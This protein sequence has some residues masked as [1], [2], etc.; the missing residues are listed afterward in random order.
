MEL[1][2]TLHARPQPGEAVSPCCG[3]TLAELPR[4]DRIAPKPEQVTCGRLS[5]DEFAL[6][7]GQPVI[8]DPYDR[9]ILF[10]MTST[11]CRLV[12]DSVTTAQA[13]ERIDEAIRQVVPH[14]K[15]LA[16]WTPELIVRVTTRAEESI[17][18]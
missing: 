10:M 2:E 11:V 8:L 9:Q 3:R 1:T 18:F 15:P 14:D 13:R 16:A 7:S 4:Y 12:G 17:Q 6:L 5:D